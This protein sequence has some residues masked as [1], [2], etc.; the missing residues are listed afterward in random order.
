MSFDVVLDR[1]HRIALRFLAGLLERYVNARDPSPPLLASLPI[2][3]SD[4]IDVLNAL[5]ALI[6]A[7]G[8]ASPGPRYFGF[9]TGGSLPVAVASDWLVSAWDQNTG[10]HVMSPAIARLEDVTAAWLLDL[11]GLP[12]DASIGFVTGA[13]MA[14]A[15]ALAAARD[16]VLRRVGWDVERDG[17]QGAPRVTMIAGAEARSAIDSACRLL[18]FGAARIVRVAADAQGRMQSDGLREALGTVRPPSIVCLQAGHVNT[19]A[20]DPSPELIGMARGAG[21]WVHVDGAFGLWAK[22]AASLRPLA[23]GVEHAD[24]WAVDAHKWLN[25]PHDSGLAIV[26]HPAAHR[27]AMAQTASYLLPATGER[28]DGMDWTPEASRRA[29][30][31]PTCAVL[32]TLGRKDVSDLVTRHCDR[33]TQMAERLR[34]HPRITILNDVVLNQVLVRVRS[35]SGATITCDVVARIQQDGVCWVGG[36]TWS[37]QPAMR[38]SMSNWSTTSDDIDRSAASILS[39]AR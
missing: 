1:A 39:A 19:G 9:V 29:R 32:R 20:F 30:A 26:A 27:A 33:A 22:A 3:P 10:L 21:A 37:G 31:V 6:E 16:E 11:F 8:I 7:G 15:T 4:P 28:R 24:S 14:N 5:D 35:P 34:A 17:L 18:G 23:D 36:T 12:P 38:I 2:D 13:T 25:V